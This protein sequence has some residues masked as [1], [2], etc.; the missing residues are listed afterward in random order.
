MLRALGFGKAQS[1][2]GVGCFADGMTNRFQ[3]G[4]QT[5]TV[6]RSVLA[7]ENGCHR[8]STGAS[9]VRAMLRLSEDPG[10]GSIGERSD[11]GRR[12][13]TICWFCFQANHD[14]R[15]CSLQPRCGTAAELESIEAGPNRCCMSQRDPRLSGRYDPR[16]ALVSPRMPPGRWVRYR[17]EHECCVKGPPASESLFLLRR[18]QGR[19]LH[20]STR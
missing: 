8:Q 16:S 17:R 12:N 7:D 1:F 10:F 19:L 5:L 3:E 18:P 9:S 4:G 20:Q 6:D 2:S 11:E 15:Q 14:C 13:R